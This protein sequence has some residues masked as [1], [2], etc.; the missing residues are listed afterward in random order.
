VRQDG[1]MTRIVVGQDVPL[2]G[3]QRW[4]VTT[5]RH[6]VEEQRVI[7]LAKQLGADRSGALPQAGLDQAKAA[8]L[9]SRPHIDP[10]GASWRE[11]SAAIDTAG[12]GP[13]LAV[14]EGVAGAG[15]TTLLSP[16]VATAK[17]ERRRVHGLARGWKQA[18]ALQE[19][20]IEQTDI[21]ATST[22]LNRIE[23]GKLHLDKDSIVIL[24]ELSQIGR[25]EMLKLMDLQQK[26]GFRMIAVGDP[27]QGG[28]IDPE[29]I[30]LL[31]E[32]L[33]D[34]VPRILTSVRQR[35]EREREIAG[36]FREGG[37][38]THQA[39]GMKRADGHA[40][41]VAGGRAATI[42]HVASLWRERVEAR[43]GDTDFKLTISAPTNRD[44]HDIGVAIRQQAR[45]MGRLGADKA[46]VRVALRGEKDLQPLVLAAGDR[47][48]L[49]NRVVVDRR[50]FVSNG[51]TVT[52]LDANNDAMRV[53]R[54]DGTEATVKYD[55]L[56][57]RRQMP[58]Q[59]AYV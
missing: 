50:H 27:K 20:G 8:F 22:F 59:L 39:I 29:V 6:E 2:R 5:E 43:G 18:T 36:L 3:V 9:A 46:T 38:A 53:R 48:R 7:E 56:R 47:V 21:A 33:G 26:R 35:T 13:R 51:D 40:I 44:A 19:A 31:T 57:T 32:T 30:G 4:S 14:I 16:L 54:D 17:A 42:Q 23:K 34:K 24:D 37:T 55:Q 58:V 45:E 49:F 15:K 12:T 10:Q 28:S 25:R 52:V 11:Q 41:A 1:E